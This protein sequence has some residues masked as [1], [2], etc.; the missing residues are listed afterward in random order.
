MDFR[1]FYLHCECDI[2]FFE[3]EIADKLKE[4]YLN[5]CD[6]CELVTE[7]KNKANIFTRMYRSI[8]RIFA[9]LM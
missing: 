9:P 2:M 5:T 4:D 3:K 6:E 1:S 8:L 7:K